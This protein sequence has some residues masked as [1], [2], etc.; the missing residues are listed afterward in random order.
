MAALDPGKSHRRLSFSAI[1]ALHMHVSDIVM[2]LP[3]LFTEC[4]TSRSA[5][6]QASGCLLVA[7]TYAL[8]Q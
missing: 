2:I 4:L 1:A 7:P 8:F 6:L 3:L 5:Q